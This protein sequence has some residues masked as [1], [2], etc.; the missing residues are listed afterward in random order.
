MEENKSEEKKDENSESET[1][2]E[3]IQI[4]HA[5]VLKSD[6]VLLCYRTIELIKNLPDGTITII[7]VCDVLGYPGDDDRSIITV[8]MDNVD[9]IQEYYHD[10]LWDQLMETVIDSQM[11][12]DDENPLLYG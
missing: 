3:E 4:T 1:T 8:N 12:V 9:Y 7:L 5:V 10:D 6:E 11:N 2:G